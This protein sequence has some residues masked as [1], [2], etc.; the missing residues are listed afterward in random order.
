MEA[1]TRDPR[2]VAQKAELFLKQTGIADTVY[3]GPELEFF[4]FDSIKFDQGHNFGFYHIDSEAG[5]W[6]SGKE[7]LG[8]TGRATSRATSRC[9]R[10]TTSRTSGRRWC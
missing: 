1:Y 6:N 10:W 2:Y 7:G 9:R 3:I 8:A 4:I 5:V